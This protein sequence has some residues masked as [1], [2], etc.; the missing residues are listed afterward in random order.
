MDEEDYGN[1]RAYDYV[2]IRQNDL[3][4]HD[5][6][7]LVNEVE[8]NNVRSWIWSDYVWHNPDI[9]YKKMPKSVLQSNWYYGE[10]FDLEK[11]SE[12][13][14]VRVKTYADLEKH[15]YDQVPTGSNHGND[16]NME[17]TVDYCK[18]VIDSSRLLGFMT[19]PWRPTL[20]PCL[21]THKEAIDQLG[22]AIKS[23]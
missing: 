9:F 1:Q 18:N 4:W 13:A 16:L 17:A 20:A 14:G 2:T 8:K 10:H 11:L 7:F 21:D 15:G 12:S 19:A 23:F 6:Y 3:W 22:R 5:F